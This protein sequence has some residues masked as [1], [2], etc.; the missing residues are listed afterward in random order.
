[1]KSNFDASLVRKALLCINKDNRRDFRFFRSFPRVPLR[2]ILDIGAHHGE[3]TDR[4][5][6]HHPVEKIILF[7]PSPES[8]TVLRRRYR[9]EPRCTIEPIALSDRTETTALRLLNKADSNSLLNPVGDAST[10]L[11]REF[12]EIGQTQIETRCL[13]DIQSIRDIPR[14]DLAKIDVQGAELKVLR[15]CGVLLERIQAIYIEVNFQ[16]LYQDGAVFCETHTFLEQAGFKLGFMQEFRRNPE[17]VLI[18]GNAY[19]FRTSAV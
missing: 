2:T 14:F 6:R 17:G 18:Y 3:F 4:V 1:V 10:L 15:G 9:H 5:L 8:I 19:Y 16:S 11:Q 12:Y 13:R 7:E